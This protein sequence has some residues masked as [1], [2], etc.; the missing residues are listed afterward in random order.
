VIPY[1]IEFNKMNIWEYA[2]MSKMSK[3]KVGLRTING[4]R[5]IISFKRLKNGRYEIHTKDD[6]NSPYYLDGDNVVEV[7][8]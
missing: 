4:F 7:I 8:K 5:E 3:T 1:S 6:I 2:L